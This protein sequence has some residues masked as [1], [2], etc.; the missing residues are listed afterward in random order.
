MQSLYAIHLAADEMQV[1][2]PAIG[3]QGL[4][5]AAKSSYSYVNMLIL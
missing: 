2:D 1:V 4:L 5:A 3:I